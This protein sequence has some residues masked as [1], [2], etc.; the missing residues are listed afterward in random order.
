MVKLTS[1][2]LLRG[3]GL[4]VTGSPSPALTGCH[5]GAYSIPYNQRLTR[6]LQPRPYLTSFLKIRGSHPDDLQGLFCGL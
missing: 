3:L 5:S 2:V 4:R 6:A 1:V